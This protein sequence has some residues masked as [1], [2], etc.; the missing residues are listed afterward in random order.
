MR[1]SNVPLDGGPAAPRDEDAGVRD[2]ALARERGFRS[3]DP[4]GACDDERPHGRRQA[5]GRTRPA[6]LPNGRRGVPVPSGNY[7]ARRRRGGRRLGS[8]LS[9]GPGARSR[10]ADVPRRARGVPGL[11]VLP[12][13]GQGEPARVHRAVSAG[14][15]G[16]ARSAGRGPGRPPCQ[17]S[18]QLGIRSGYAAG[19]DACQPRPRSASARPPVRPGTPGFEDPR[20]DPSRRPRRRSPHAGPSPRR[21]AAG[22]SRPSKGD[23]AH[24]YGDGDGGLASHPPKRPLR[25][26][27][28]R[29]SEARE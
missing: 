24:R 17:A 23:V 21:R 15:R 26:D 8:Q 9:G 7:R 3:G 27:D 4:A 19:P 29:G 20:G 22:G 5:S 1:R 2:G 14:P 10:D 6:R 28:R 16:H 13:R 12:S 18:R 25:A 11:P